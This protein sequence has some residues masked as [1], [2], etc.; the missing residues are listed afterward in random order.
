MTFSDYGPA[1]AGALRA[2]QLERLIQT[3]VHAYAHSPHYRAAFDRAGIAPGD[4]RSL[5]DI[6]RLPFSSQLQ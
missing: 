1:D 2:L 4:I 6:R 5:A 3:V